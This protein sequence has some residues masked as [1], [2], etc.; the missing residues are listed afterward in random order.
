MQV[1]KAEM[2]GPHDP[3]RGPERGPAARGVEGRDAE[4]PRPRDKGT[5]RL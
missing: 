4:A 2:P 1:L 3:L 5:G